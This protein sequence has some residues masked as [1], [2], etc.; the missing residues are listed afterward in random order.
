MVKL[1][2]NK[3][4]PFTLVI[5]ILGFASPALAV[6]PLIVD[7]KTNY[8]PGTEFISTQT[9][10]D[11]GLSQTFPAYTTDDF[12]SGER[13]A[14]YELAE[15]RVYRVTVNLLKPDGSILDSRAVL[16]DFRDV[17]LAITVLIS[18]V[19]DPPSDSCEED[20][21]EAEQELAVV[22]L[23]LEDTQIE[24]VQ[25]QADLS[26]AQQ[27]LQ[28]AN[29][30]LTQLQ[31]DSDGDGVINILDQCGQTEEGEE[32]DAL[33]CSNQQF[34]NQ[35]PVENFRDILPCLAAD[36]NEDDP[37]FRARDCKVDYENSAC[38]AR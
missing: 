9:L 31:G 10:V 3:L 35:N 12:V 1:F 38:V 7:L 32:V 19:G 4:L 33:G 26:Q 18:R 30:Q 36:W 25:T 2:F 16:V 23:E 24:L 29:A 5:V 14:E 34:C 20:L 15:N 21:A 17:A 8:L 28:E 13:V 11:G 22:T 6:K 37:L 27:L